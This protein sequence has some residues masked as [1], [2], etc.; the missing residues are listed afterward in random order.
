WGT[1]EELIEALSAPEPTALVPAT[2]AEPVVPAAPEPVSPS[3]YPTLEIGQ[4]LVD[5][6]FAARER[7]RRRRQRWT[8]AAIIALVLSGGLGALAFAGRDPSP[9]A[10]FAARADD[11]ALD[12]SGG[13]VD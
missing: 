13:P 5:E 10:A 2:W 8:A 9:T 12:E 7:A 11:L 1:A 4:S 6:V 3:D